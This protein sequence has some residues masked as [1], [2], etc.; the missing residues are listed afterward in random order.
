MS[1]SASGPV[2]GFLFQFEKAIALLATLQNKDDTVSLEMF[3]DIAAQDENGLVIATIQA[4]H[5]IALNGSTFA[6]TST[7][8]WRTLEIWIQKLEDGAF[9]NKTDFICA[10]NKKIPDEALIKKIANGLLEDAIKSM[11]DLLAEQKQKLKDKKTKQEEKEKGGDKEVGA[12]MSKIITLIEFVLSKPDQ[13]KIIHNNLKI[14]DEQNPKEKFLVAVHMSGNSFSAER[15]NR[16]FESM[17]GWITTNSRA[18]WQN[19]SPAKF[20]KID[21]DERLARDNSNPSII[22]AV[23]RKKETLGTIAS[24][25]IDKMKTEL[26]VRQIEDIPRNSEAKKRKI[27]NAILDF[28]YHEIE[29]SHV[30]T[31]R[32]DLTE[33]DF[34]TFRN[35]CKERWQDCYDSLVL[36]ELEEYDDDAKNQLAIQIF[37]KVMDNLAVKF[38]E[39]IQFDASNRYIHN[40]TFLKLSNIPEIGWHP[41]WKSKYTN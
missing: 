21:F 36:K 26:F 4:K 22:N 19:G 38:Q 41:E 34:E 1:D 35:N 24:S 5:S 14:E 39:G 16:T 32:G 27:E 25:Q 10:T 31:K 8:L 2:A 33:S 30:I 3:D 29:M 7:A 40:G 13:F 28:I 6:D 18:K 15:K 9:N 23:F 12:S 17:C 37:E 20:S 11:Q